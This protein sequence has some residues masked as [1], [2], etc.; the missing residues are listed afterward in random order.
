MSK[1]YCPS[2]N[3]NYHLAANYQLEAMKQSF[4]TCVPL[5]VFEPHTAAQVP[6]VAQQEHT[7]L[8]VACSSTGSPSKLK[9][10]FAKDIAKDV[11]DIPFGV[12]R[13]YA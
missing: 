1:G 9:D 5:K 8:I 7:G 13:P 6:V 12:T 3:N 11:V 2:R 10:P 4:D